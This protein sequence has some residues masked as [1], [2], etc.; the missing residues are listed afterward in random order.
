MTLFFVFK[1]NS[2]RYLFSLHSWSD[3]VFRLLFVQFSRTLATINS[4]IEQ[5]LFCSQ[6]CCFSVCVGPTCV[7]FRAQKIAVR[8]FWCYTCLRALTTTMN[9]LIMDSERIKHTDPLVIVHTY[10]LYSHFC[11][12]IIYLCFCFFFFD[13]KICELFFC[14]LL[15]Q[16]SFVRRTAVA[17]GAASA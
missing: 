1:K 7:H 2:L 14:Y 5:V 8:L 10:I 12:F 16:Q 17:D 6:F 13:T 11:R 3:S 4:T 15:H 9:A